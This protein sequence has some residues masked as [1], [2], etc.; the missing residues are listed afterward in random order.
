MQIPILIDFLSLNIRKMFKII[1]NFNILD[2]V[3]GGYTDWTSWTDCSKDCHGT[4]TKQRYCNNPTPC[5]GGND[6]TDLG[7]DMLVKDCGKYKVLAQINQLHVLVV[8][9]ANKTLKSMCAFHFQ[10]HK[11]KCFN[12]ILYMLY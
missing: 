8:I 2:V 12:F 11:E 6:C 10:C 7:A 4:A 3:D 9:V 5:N 1:S